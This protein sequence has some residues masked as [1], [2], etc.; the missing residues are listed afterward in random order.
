MQFCC[1][2]TFEVVAM[3]LQVAP[4]SVDLKIPSPV[5]PECVEP[6]PM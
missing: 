2:P 4:A 3:R 6:V 1:A 5:A